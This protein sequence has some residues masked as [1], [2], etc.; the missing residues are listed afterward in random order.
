MTILLSPLLVD[1]NCH[2]YYPTAPICQGS[3]FITW[4]GRCDT[5]I[6][7]PLMKKPTKRGTGSAGAVPFHGATPF[8]EDDDDE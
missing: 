1:F 8:G 2:K 3:S 7:D 6:V 5:C 4:N